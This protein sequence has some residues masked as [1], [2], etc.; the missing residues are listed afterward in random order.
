M[1]ADSGR[2]GVRHVGQDFGQRGGGQ[3][4]EFDKRD[5][6]QPQQLRDDAAQ[7]VAAVQVVG[8]VRADDR[9]ALAVQHAGEE[10]DQVAR[11][12]VGPVQV[13]DDKQDRAVDGELGQQAEHGAEHLLARQARPVRLLGLPVAVR[14]AGGTA[15]GAP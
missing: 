1:A 9:D 10:R 4:P 8:A 5:H 14:A 7:R 11:G 15:P 3:R 2:R 6:G 13:L 12:G